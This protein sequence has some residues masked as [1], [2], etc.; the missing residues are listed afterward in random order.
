MQLPNWDE[1]SDFFAAQDDEQAS[2]RRKAFLEQQ[3]ESCQTA[4]ERDDYQSIFMS[5]YGIHIDWKEGIFSLL[6]ALSETLGEATFSAEFDYD[7]DIE[8]ATIDF[9]G[10]QSVFHHYSIGCDEYD[11]EHTRI[12]HLLLLGGYALRVHRESMMSDTLSFLLMPLNEWKR[13]EQ[14]FGAESIS[15]HFTPYESLCLESEYEETT[16]NDTSANHQ[17]TYYAGLFYV[18]RARIL[19]WCVLP[20]LAV[21]MLGALWSALTST[22]PLPPSQPKGC[23]NVEKVHSKLRPEVAE[24]LKARMRKSL[25]CQ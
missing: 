25:G 11:M 13:A 2:V 7:S 17:K 22:E 19:F 5:V 9:A 24:P 12:E 23:E 1:F 15:A 18:W 8:S 6:E 20:V 16:A 10:G 14:Q 21:F 4:L 3:G